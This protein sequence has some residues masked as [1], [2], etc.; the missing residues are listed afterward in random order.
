[1]KRIDGSGWT[2]IGAWTCAALA[3]C[4]AQG[5][6]IV[7]D[8]GRDLVLNEACA[9]VYT[10]VY[11]GVWS[12]L[13][14]ASWDPASPR[15]PMAKTRIYKPGTKDANGQEI[16][17]E[18]GP[19]A[20]STSG[21]NTFQ[22]PV[23]A[24]NPRTVEDTANLTAAGYPTI[25]PG[26]ISV[27]PGAGKCAILR[28]TAPR[29]GV[30]AITAKFWNQ[31]K[32]VF[33]MTVQTN[34]VVTKA[35]EAWTGSLHKNEIYDFSLP[36]TTYRAG[37]TVE[38]TVDD[39][40]K[41]DSNAA[42]VIFRIE[43]E[44]AEVIDAGAAMR[45]HVLADGAAATAAW[46][47]AAGAWRVESVSATNAVKNLNRTLLD[48]RS[49]RTT[50]GS[51]AS[52]WSTSKT[53][54]PWAHVNATDA[55]VV[56][57]NASGVVTL[58]RG[59]SL[60][61]GELYLHP[62]KQPGTG[63]AGVHSV[64]V[65]LSPAT[66]GRYDIGVTLRDVSWHASG[67][68]V[69]VHLIQGG[70]ELAVRRISCE[71]A[72]SPQNATIFL[73][74]VAVAAG[75][76]VELV[77]DQVGLH[78]ADG[79]GLFWAMVRTSDAGVYSANAAL[80]A[81]LT[82]ASPA[83]TYTGDGA[84]WQVGLWNNGTLTPFTTFQSARTIGP[85]KAMGNTAGTSPFMGANLKGRALTQAETSSNNK[86]AAGRD[87]IIGHP[88]G[89]GAKSTLRFTAPADGVY[90]V[91]AFAMDLDGGGSIG[92]AGDGV[93]MQIFT[94]GHQA[95]VMGLKS[96]TNQIDYAELDTPALHL[97][98]GEAADIVINPNAADANGHTC[99]LTGLY[100]WL[101]CDASTTDR[102]H[103]N[104]DFDAPDAQGDV[105]TFAGAGR[106]GYSGE[107]WES[108]RV[109]AAAEATF[110]RAVCIGGADD[111]KRAGLVLTLS[112]GDGPLVCDAGNT[113]TTDVGAAAKA[114]FV[115]GVVSASSD[116]PVTF[117][118]SGLLPGE[119]YMLGFCSRRRTATGN[120]NDATTVRGEFTVNG[121]TDRST[122]PWFALGF[123]D[124]ANLE[125]TADANGVVT[126][127]FASFSDEPAYW[128]GLQV[129]GPGFAKYVPT[130]TYIVVR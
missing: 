24:V 41:L 70:H 36:A 87:M 63:E 61:P 21:G 66:S 64:L 77:V 52:G 83:A 55:L 130:G 103:V 73:R 121:V 111:G 91:H 94:G 128:N 81:N 75:V 18:R 72:A 84:T 30:Y 13:T 112:R 79:T 68:G 28:F 34:G 23:I 29:T 31:N 85:D 17:V 109:P 40:G 57:T 51:G 39:N 108:F 80:I 58:H 113:L 71:Q 129:E 12:F 65:G 74:D 120:A 6:T 97:K 22:L 99:D 105:A 67:D 8:A 119:T 62:G 15:V 53:G 5:A 116:D 7:H 35:R 92:N 25:K 107:V 69:R 38:F 54:T 4:C 11:G 16:V 43:E 50:Q 20:E 10:N 118:L 127:T 93:V 32:G 115:D 106:Y 76:P 3:A 49:V 114:L 96:I 102:A 48:T 60:V 110:K 47:D 37:D 117:T 33:G 46:T 123:G 122:H 2:R 95:R 88:G 98:A 42:G 44:V 125:V 86:I 90:S 19:N 14:A 1:M 26:Q 27:H 101:S 45:A 100:V 82:S 78:T 89:S 126:G 9:N 104:I 124:Y 56:E 59:T